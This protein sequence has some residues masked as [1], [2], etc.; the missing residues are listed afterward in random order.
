MTPQ[1]VL[2]F[3]F[4]EENCPFWFAKSDKFDQAIRSRFADLWQ[5][6]ARAE[7]YG[8]RATLEGRLAEIIVLDQFSRNLFR[9]NPQA[10]ACDAMAQVLAQEAAKQPGF[11]DL[12]DTWRHM[13]LMPLMHSEKPHNPRPCVGTLHPPR[14]PRADT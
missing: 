3:W 4:A 1:T 14:R 12:P 10:F 8:W 13:V 2:D 6:A 5:Q 9:N 7:L 11:A